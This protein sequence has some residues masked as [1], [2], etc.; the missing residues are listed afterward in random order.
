MKTI[1]RVI[2]IQTFALFLTSQLL[3]GLSIV[4]GWSTYLIGGVL[5]SILSFALK[6][7]LQVIAF[8]L[9]LITFGLFNCVINALLLWVLTILVARINV[10]IFRTPVV[11]TFGITIPS[12]HIYS[13]IPAYVVIAVVLAAITWVLTWIVKS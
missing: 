8:P 1:A 9:N 10:H 13:I 5:L 11:A 2:F 7:L 4:G 3:S 6:P 12:V